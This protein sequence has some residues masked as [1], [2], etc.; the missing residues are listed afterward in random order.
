MRSFTALLVLSLIIAVAIAQDWPANDFVITSP[1]DIP[2]TPAKVYTW[3]TPLKIPN[4]IDHNG[5]IKVKVVADTTVIICINER[6]QVVSGINSCSPYGRLN[7]TW[8]NKTETP[9]QDVYLRFGKTYYVSYVLEWNNNAINKSS[10]VIV[11]SGKACDDP[12]KD[13]FNCGNKQ[14][15]SLTDNVAHPDTIKSGQTNWYIYETTD[16]R[17]SITVKVYNPTDLLQTV[18]VGK[19]AGLP[20]Y[21]NG[22][23]TLSTV[24][25]EGMPNGKNESDIV[26]SFPQSS[27]Y[28]FAVINKEADG[29]KP[30][31][32][33]SIII[34]LGPTAGVG[35]MNA[36]TPH[37]DS[38]KENNTVK[39]AASVGQLNNSLNYFKFPSTSLL[40]LG[41]APEDSDDPTPDVYVDV[42]L[43]PS[44]DSNIIK[45]TNKTEPAHLLF[46]TTT[47]TNSR[48]VWYQFEN[49]SP[50]VKDDSFWYVAVNS[51]NAFVLWSAENGTCANNCTKR[52]V[53]DETTGIC[54][55]DDGY[56]KYDCSEKVFPLV[57]IILIAIGG[58]ILL[59]IA[60][61]VPVSC[62]LKN[63]KKSGYERV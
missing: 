6:V 32:G 36:S 30:D 53:C 9:A 37:F 11:I 21:E 19:R 23:L 24:D 60:I 62:Y 33:F 22:N 4:N 12:S 46:A 44:P 14:P 49:T 54:I 15:F 48:F 38:K 52:G 17:Q 59:A 26:L 39:F 2:Q 1:G 58:A 51:T 42:D 50:T 35:M 63:K 57:W 34:Q 27:K 18:L 43:I 29:T 8:V 40:R 41:I 31:V 45:N 55:C 56:E 28:W 3:A 61:G 7:F 10:V 20:L 16:Q 13:G 47:P 5:K 25:W